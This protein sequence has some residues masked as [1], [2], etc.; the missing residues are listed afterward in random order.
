MQP[1]WLDLIYLV[2]IVAAPIAFELRGGVARMKAKIAAGVPNVRRKT[3][4]RTIAFQ[5]ALS[6]PVVI[7]WIVTRRPWSALAIVP[8]TSALRAT[9]SAAII[10][11]TA[12]FGVLQ[13]IS[14]RKIAAS[15]ATKARYRG[16]LAHV[17]FMMPRDRSEYRLFATLSVIAGVCEEFL[18]RGYMIWVLDAYMS[19]PLAVLVSAALFGVAHTYQGR[20]QAA[21]IGVIA[22]LMNVVVWLGGWLVPAM[23][24]H[25][26]FN[27]ATGRLAYVVLRT[28]GAEPVIGSLS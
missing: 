9:A 18:F 22:V 23:V 28:P 17:D 11:A 13:M 4:L 12:I 7:G 2:L 3:Y 25:A 27:A 8:P 21:K 14:I 10:V 1:T 19:F 24:L 20:R 5:F 15:D 16:A 26:V 6:L